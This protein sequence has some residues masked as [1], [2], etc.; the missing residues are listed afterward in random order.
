MKKTK[1]YIF[2]SLMTAFAV[3]LS[4][5]ENIIPLPIALPG[6]KLGLSNI[7]ILSSLIV[8]GFKDSLTINVTRTVLVLLIMGNPISFIYSL[9]GALFSLVIMYIVYKFFSQ[10]FSLVGISIFGA[11]AHNTAQVLTAS[12]ILEN[13]NILSYLPLMYLISLFTGFFVGFS[14]NFVVKQLKKILNNVYWR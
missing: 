13:A 9:S 1:K 5:F 8:F 6:A 2:L 11:V 7:V 4:L 14:S 3:L 12:L 10:Y